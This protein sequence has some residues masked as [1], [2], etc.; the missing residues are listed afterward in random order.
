MK[1]Y[2]P[3]MYIPLM[4]LSASIIYALAGCQSLQGLYSWSNGASEG[5]VTLKKIPENQPAESE[6]F[7]LDQQGV[8]LEA[9]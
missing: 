9:R 3:L 2:I 6:K 1:N 5:T 4:L 7:I 8:I